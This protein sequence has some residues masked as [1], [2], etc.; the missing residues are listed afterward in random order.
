MFSLSP[1][2]TIREIDLTTTVPTVAT[3]IAGLVGDF[4][5]GPVHEIRQ[6]YSEDILKRIY[7]EPTKRTAKDWFSAS[8]FLSYSN[9]LKVA[10]TVIE[11]ELNT[12][13]YIDPSGANAAY[14]AYYNDGSS[15]DPGNA[16]VKNADHLEN[17]AFDVLSANDHSIVAKWPGSYGDNIAV[18]IISGSAWQDYSSEITTDDWA[19]VDEFDN[20]PSYDASNPED[21]EYAIVVTDNG[22]VVETFIVSKN[23]DAK[24][25]TGKSLYADDVINRQSAYIWVLGENLFA[26]GHSDEFQDEYLTGGMDG[27][28]IGES[29]YL[30]GWDL[31]AVAEEVDVNLL[32]TGGADQLSAKYVL[33]NVAEERLDC[34]AFI[35]PQEGSVVGSRTPTDDV[36]DDRFQYPSSSYGFYD[37]NYKYQY[38]RYNDSFHWIPLNAD[39]AGLAARTDS[40]TEAWYSPAGYNRGII[41]NTVKLAFNPSKANRDKLYKNNVN[42]VINEKG[43]GTLLF[44]D[45]TMQAKPSAF[46]R[47]NVRRLFIV[48]EKAISTFAKYQ[49]FEFNDEVTR[50]RFVNAVTPFLR[51]VQ[52]RRG[53]DEFKVV[54]DETNN[55]PY[56]I[57]NNSFVADIYIKPVYSINFIRLNFVAVSPGVSFEEVVGSF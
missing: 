12:G 18:S 50:R 57:Q 29:E 9:N 54:C 48:L 6:V 14:N 51:N 17:E 55:T 21:E 7:G 33:Q 22:V 23:P 56:V 10:R 30:T 35:S 46:D 24:D 2:V 42:P 44:G 38:D 28:L 40:S 49:L 52:S 45:K 5:W 25:F 41:K 3:S 53:I 11:P 47:I 37:G 27:D 19:Y 32:I 13:D 31:F 4:K 39:M 16:F 34:V 20:A 36:V 26:S 1:A 43:Q 15:P 8:N